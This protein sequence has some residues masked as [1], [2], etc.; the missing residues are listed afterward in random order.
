MKCVAVVEISSGIRH[1]VDIDFIASDGNS[2]ASDTALEES[3]DRSWLWLLVAGFWDCKYLPGNL[4]LN[5]A[6]WVLA[7]EGVP[8]NAATAAVANRANKSLLD[9]SIQVFGGWA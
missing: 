8:A 7:S 3:L 9:F 4:V 2:D 1:T 5:T 6:A